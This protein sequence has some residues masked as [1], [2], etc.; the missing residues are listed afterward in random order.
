[1]SNIAHSRKL[2]EL[3]HYWIQI[4]T[5]RRRRSISLDAGGRTQ[6]RLHAWVVVVQEQEMAHQKSNTVFFAVIGGSLLAAA[7]LV[8]LLVGGQFAGPKVAF[9]ATPP[10][11]AR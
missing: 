4:R 7:L 11:T 2:H 6:E 8:A 5:T 10:I 9:N 1:M 3:R